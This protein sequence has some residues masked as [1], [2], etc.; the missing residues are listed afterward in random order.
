M[1]NFELYERANSRVSRRVGKSVTVQRRGQIAFSADAL[2]E[3]GH[4]KA[5]AFL[6]D[7]DER[8]LGFRPASPRTAGAS[9]IRATG[10][11]ASAVRVLRYLNVD[12]SESR[13]YPLAC[14][15]GVHYIDLKQPGVVVTSNRRGTGKR[16]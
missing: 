10:H 4:P 8:L 6:V 7:R 5:V 14:E 13:R 3:L 11:I 15:D 16:P 12:L 1:P 2:A 9:V